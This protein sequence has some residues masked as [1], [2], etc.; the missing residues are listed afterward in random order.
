MPDV[1]FGADIAYGGLNEIKQLVDEVGSYTNLFVLGCPAVTQNRLELEEACQYL[2]DKGLFF[3][4]YQDYPLDLTW[5]SSANSSWL[6]IAKTRWGNHFLGFYYVDEVG[7]RQLDLYPKWT[8]VSNA[9][10]Y[11][12]ASSQFNSRKRIGQLV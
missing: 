2:F 4:V 1:F 9:D 5:F 6:Q 7:G 12:N 8:I 3:I 11:A 10:S